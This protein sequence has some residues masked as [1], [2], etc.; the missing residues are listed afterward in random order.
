V[1]ALLKKFSEDHGDFP[2]ISMSY[3]G[4]EQANQMTRLEAFIHQAI[5]R[6]NDNVL[7]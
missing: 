3:D 6:M 5:Q 7:V 1:T 4:N 2:Y